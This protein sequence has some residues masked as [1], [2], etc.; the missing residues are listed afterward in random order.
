M[1][2]S[3]SLVTAAARMP[4]TPAQDPKRHLEERVNHLLSTNIVQLL[5]AMVDTIVF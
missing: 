5:T 1:E 4:L 2:A 3:R